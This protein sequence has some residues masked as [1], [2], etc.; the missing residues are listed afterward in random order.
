MS[1]YPSQSGKSWRNSLQWKLLFTLLVGAIV[2]FAVLSAVAG[3]NLLL[4][5]GGIVALIAHLMGLLFAWNVWSGIF[6]QATALN[7]TLERINAGDYE[8]RVRE[9]TDDELG[10]SAALLNDMCDNTL[11]L[12]HSSDEQANIQAS[13]DGLVN[14]MQGIAA[15]DLTI[16]AEV[17]HDVTGSIAKSVNHMTGQLRSLVDKVQSATEQVNDSASHIRASSTLMSEES[18]DQAQRISKA[19]D[20]LLEM[21]TA[22]QNVATL[23]EESVQVAVEARQTASNG[24]KAVND[25]VEGMQRIRTQVQNTS[26]RI[27][28]LG[29]SSQEIGEIVQMISDIAD[30]TSILAL[31]ASIQAAMA[32]DAGQGFAVVAE[33]VERLAES[34]AD[35]SN[36]IAKLIR[37]IQTE[38]SEAIS[39]MEESTR[40]VVT[41]SQLASQAG[42]TLFEIDSVSNQLVELIESV[43]ASALTQADDATKVAASMAEISS[44][45]KDSAEKSRNATESVGQLAEMANVLR[46][47]VSRFR[48][49]GPVSHDD[50][51]EI[52]ADEDEA[53]VEKVTET[54]VDGVD[55][56]QFVVDQLKAV[57]DILTDKKTEDADEEGEPEEDVC[58]TLNPDQ[59]TSPTISQTIQLEDM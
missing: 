52:E 53:P 59:E 31:N 35:A 3:S 17:G 12:I 55:Q 20:R 21:T 6:R 30:R 22:F 57:S 26:K 51:V 56:E 37:G 41:G 32:G 11:N 24:L 25:T 15:G 54:Q 43:S 39:D 23:T 36:Q 44:S 29:E 40:E 18:D 45:T 1:H 5:T 48:V 19:S 14:Q 50:V 9:L 47:S 38:T 16:S 13:I 46:G 49:D 7:T 27:K 34:S 10:D 8:A 2:P 58:R 4:S 33:E 28:R 42:E